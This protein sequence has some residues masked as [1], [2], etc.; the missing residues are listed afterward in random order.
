MTIHLREVTPNDAEALAHILI[1]AGESAF[2]GIV[3]DICLQFTEA[4]SAANWKEFFREGFSRGDF[5]LIA[6]TEAG[7]A[8]AYAWGGTRADDSL[9]PGELRQISVLPDYHRQGIGR[10]LVREV[11]RRLSEQ[12]IHSMLVEVLRDN[13][14]RAFYERLGGV[15]VFER[16]YDWDGY[17]TPM[18]AY[19]WTDTRALLD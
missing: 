3:P 18:Y 8:V 17:I 2:R 12:G 14:N 10:L 15:F 7:A 5:M 16:P 9:Y 19:G 13:P 11:A 4:Q 1:T 6:E